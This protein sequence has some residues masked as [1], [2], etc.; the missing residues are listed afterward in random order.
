MTPVL[1]VAAAQLTLTPNG[2]VGV[3]VMPPGVVGLVVSTVQVA[4]AGVGSTDRL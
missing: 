2:D 1:S 4:I 3:A